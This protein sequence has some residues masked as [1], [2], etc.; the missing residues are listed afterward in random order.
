[1][2]KRLTLLLYVACGLLVAAD[3]LYHKHAHFATDA[4]FGFYAFYGFIAAVA[5]IAAG[6]VVGT[7][8]SGKEDYYD[9]E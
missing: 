6:R 9:A 7:F 3:L 5:L 2:S 4:T 8:F 1:M